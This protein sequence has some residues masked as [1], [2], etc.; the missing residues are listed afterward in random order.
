MSDKINDFAACSGLL[1]KRPEFTVA[2][3]MLSVIFIERD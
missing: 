3:Q 1:R 2:E